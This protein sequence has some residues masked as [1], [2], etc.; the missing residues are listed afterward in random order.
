MNKSGSGRSSMQDKKLYNMKYKIIGLFFL[1]MIVSGTGISYAQ[2]VK[3]FFKQGQIHFNN[4]RYDSAIVYYNK[5]IELDSTYLNAYLQRGFCRNL[6]KE[7]KF[8]IADFS[9][10]ISLDP[11]HKW[12]YDSRGSSK[13]S[14]GDYSGAMEDFNKALE[15]DPDDQEAYNNRGFTKKAMGDKEGACADWNKS[16]KLG[17][18]EA[19][20]I[21][22]NNYCK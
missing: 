21:L 14:M 19:K 22:K 1:L 5:V 2:E 17:N 6:L 7:Y 9:K 12:A 3:E 13:N 18:E 15:L 10:V 20:I 16:K 11:S 8:A 4:A